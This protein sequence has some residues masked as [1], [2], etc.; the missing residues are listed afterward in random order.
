MKN[1]LFNNIEKIAKIPSKVSNYQVSNYIVKK[2]YL[3]GKKYIVD[4]VGNIHVIPNNGSQIMLS[5]HIDK[6]A[7]PNYIDFGSF[8]IGKL[9][10]AIGVGIILA[11]LKDYDFHALLT[12]GEE[13]G[14]IGSRF[15]VKNKLISSAVNKVIVIDVSPRKTEKGVQLYFSFRNRQASSDFIKNV[16]DTARSVNADFRPMVMT[17]INDGLVLSTI[18]KDTIALEPYIDNYHTDH[19]I[20]K[21]LDIVNTYKIAE[22]LVK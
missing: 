16:A 22:G 15:A 17:P 8:V 6:Q 5:A 10:D 2:L 4:K 19:E 20:C 21:K 7:G 13:R 12:V 14:F 18:I 1:I 11:L 3:Y 9:D